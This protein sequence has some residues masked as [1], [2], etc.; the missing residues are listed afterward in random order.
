MINFSLN[1]YFANAGTDVLRTLITY[2]K[3]D[4]NEEHHNKVDPE[5]FCGGAIWKRNCKTLDTNY[6]AS[7]KL[8]QILSFNID[9]LLD[10]EPAPII[11]TSAQFNFLNR[12][13]K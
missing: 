12:R 2:R 1:E 6:T 5:F 13:S 10:T 7:A 11:L 3:S 4:R 8:V 9:K